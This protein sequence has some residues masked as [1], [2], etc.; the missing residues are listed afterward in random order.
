MGL[1]EAR[2]GGRQSWG[3]APRRV[4]LEAGGGKSQA[5]EG[6]GEGRAD[7][8][9][10]LQVTL[11]PVAHGLEEPSELLEGVPAEGFIGVGA[12]YKERDEKG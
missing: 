9:A 5:G 3:R 6:R 8:L 7:T 12:E 4:Q 2:C 10:L 11:D 1:G